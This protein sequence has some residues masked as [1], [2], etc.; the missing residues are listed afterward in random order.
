VSFL[1]GTIPPPPPLDLGGLDL[2]GTPKKASPLP[3][4]VVL[5]SIPL[6]GAI[7]FFLP[8]LQAE[9]WSLA[10]YALTPLVAVLA[11]GWDSVSQMAGRKNPWFVIRPGFSKVLRVLVAVSLLIGVV[12]IWRIS[13]WLA[14]TAIQQGWPFLT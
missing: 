6:S 10:G 11:T 14:R 8:Q 2:S 3:L 12:H 1:P 9:W 5:V 7:Y 13:D 4:I